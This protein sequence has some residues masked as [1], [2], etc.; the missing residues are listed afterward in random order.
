MSS[1]AATATGPRAA[2]RYALMGVASLGTALVAAIWLSSAALAAD[3]LVVTVGDRDGSA[4]VQAFLPGAVTIETGDTVTFR[5]GSDVPQSVTI[6]DGPAEIAPSQ[7]PVSGWPAPAGAEPG[8]DGSPA[9]VDLGLVYYGDSGFINTGLLGE[10]AT[11][12]VAFQ[13]AG[14]Y[15]VYSVDHPG[16][17]A[18]VTVVEPGS[19]PVT[20][21]GQ[22]DAAAAA[23]RDELLGQA[24]AL[25]EARLGDVE[26]ITARDGTTTWNV[27]AGV[28]TVANQL[29]G[30]GS[31][32]LELFEFVPAT[33]AIH[34]GDTVH[35]SAVGQHTVTFPATG[36]D[37]A[38]L[39]P[40]A[41]ATTSD[42]YD[43]SRLA[44]SGVLNALTGSPSAFT[45][46]FPTAGSY[47]Y[48]CLGARTADPPW[49]RAARRLA[50]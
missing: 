30:G 9:P 10:G 29:P 14:E 17:L 23:S 42:T 3:P 47:G 2:L 15:Q 36:Q 49:G 6:G 13:V 12:S 37:P 35:W 25:R 41:P 39:D 45:L 44:S 40:Q 7:W 5:I 11:A 18:T 22:A 1:G 33:L 34:P 50:G 16:M 46:T 26:S 19:A 4:A 27:F 24:D 31:G 21:Q 20:T 43:G 48:L 8:P 38:S 28:A 32:Y